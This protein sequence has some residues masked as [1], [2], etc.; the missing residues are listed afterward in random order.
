MKDFEAR[1]KEEKPHFL[2]YN[3]YVNDI[4]EKIAKDERRR[5][6]NNHTRSV[7]RSV[8]LTDPHFDHAYSMDHPAEC[9]Y[10]LCCRDNGPIT[11]AEP[12]NA[13]M[14]GRWGSFRCDVP[15]DTLQSVFDFIANNQEELKTQFITI[16]GDYSS[17]NIW[18]LKGQELFSYTKQLTDAL[19][20]TLGANSTIEVYP[21][22][23]NHDLYPPNL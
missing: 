15:F 9:T 2:R 5:K 6:E 1:L 23:G 10:F 16:T 19:K 14:P 18:Q 4:Y 3:S 13:K 8:Q 21:T 7:V 17:H 12:K 22:L 20:K 11:L